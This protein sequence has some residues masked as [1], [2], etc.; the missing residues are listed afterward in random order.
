MEDERR[1]SRHPP[2]KMSTMLKKA[3]DRDDFPLPVRPQIPTYSGRR[4]E[5]GGESGGG[6]DMPARRRTPR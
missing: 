3:S 6:S 2:S 1:T 5:E 4:Q